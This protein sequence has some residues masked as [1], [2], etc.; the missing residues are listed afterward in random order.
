MMAVLRH[1]WACATLTRSAYFGAQ[2]VVRRFAGAHGAWEAALDAVANLDALMSLAACAEAGGAQ[3]PM[4]RPKLVPAQ[5][6]GQVR[7][8]HSY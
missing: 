1:G 2:G 8:W 6:Q 3:G 5:G 7:A 4:C